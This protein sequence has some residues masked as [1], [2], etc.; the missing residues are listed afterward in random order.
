MLKEIKQNFDINC[1]TKY[2][3]S[4]NDDEYQYLTNIIDYSVEN[5][6]IK[7][8]L[9]FLYLHDSL[10][11]PL[12]SKN[13]SEDTDDEDENEHNFNYSSWRKS[14]T[15]TYAYEINK[16]SIKDID[17]YQDNIKDNTDK[18]IKI[19]LSNNFNNDT[20]D[21]YFIKKDSWDFIL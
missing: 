21:K 9:L 14:I 7:T 11:I 15:Y 17:H 2:N 16:F 20:N 5:K 10:L 19:F 18:L 6:D 4:K 3:F 1:N 12:L 13:L 8:F